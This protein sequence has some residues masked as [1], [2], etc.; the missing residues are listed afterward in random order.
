VFDKQQ[1]INSMDRVSVPLSESLVTDY[2]SM[3]T[4]EN[5][6][7]IQAFALQSLE[8]II[9]EVIRRIM[10]TSELV[11]AVFSLVDYFN[12]PYEI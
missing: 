3:L 12:F 7:E 4:P 10:S 1:G 9:D 5:N 8:P 11:Q 2:C 6:P